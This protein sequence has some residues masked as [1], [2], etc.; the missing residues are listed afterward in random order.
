MAINSYRGL[1]VKYSERDVQTTMNSL[2]LGKINAVA[3]I[4]LTP[5]ASVS[6]L[7]D[8]RIH[9]NSTLLP[10]ATTA[11]AAVELAS[12]TMYVS[13]ISGNTA[14]ITHANNAQADRT[15]KFLIIG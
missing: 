15:F 10:M 12:G 8:F 5:S 14:T 11:N 2:L 9:P 1:K 4:T 7:I 6:S 13:G 3:E